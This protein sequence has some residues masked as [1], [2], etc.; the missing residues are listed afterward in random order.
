MFDTSWLCDL[1]SS[2]ALSTL[3]K[4]SFALLFFGDGPCVAMGAIFGAQVTWF[5][6]SNMLLDAHSKNKHKHMS[7][8]Y[9]HNMPKSLPQAHSLELY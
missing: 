8:K 7:S 9:K 3:G 1:C 6:L 5:D 2:H 4:L